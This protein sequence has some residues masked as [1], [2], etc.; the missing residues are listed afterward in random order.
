MQQGAAIVERRGRHQ[1]SLVGARGPL[2]RRRIRPPRDRRRS[3][4][5]S[6]LRRN[7]AARPSARRRS[8]RVSA[9][10]A[11]RCSALRSRVTGARPSGRKI[12]RLSGH[13]SR[14]AASTAIESDAY[15]STGMPRLR[16]CNCGREPRAT[17]GG[18]TARRRAQSPPPRRG[19]RSI[20]ARDVAVAFDLRPL[21]PVEVAACG[22][23]IARRVETLRGDHAEVDAMH[24][25][26][27]ARC[28]RP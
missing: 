11:S 25:A 3:S 23:R 13:A 12:A 16:Q 22:D 28:A 7:R 14:P 9:G 17:A 4:G 15:Q 6:R 18:R 24:R 1:A 27:L 19:R 2:H 21:E 26:I 20:V 10:L 8:V 5:R